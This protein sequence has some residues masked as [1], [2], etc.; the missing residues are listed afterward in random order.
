MKTITQGEATLP[1]DL[2]KKMKPPKKK[3]IEA[4]EAEKIDK[5]LIKFKKR[6][7]ETPRCRKEIEADGK[8]A[9]GNQQD[10]CT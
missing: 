1:K 3:P 7:E 5:K 9:H 4:L 10:R 6:E 8:S 2:K